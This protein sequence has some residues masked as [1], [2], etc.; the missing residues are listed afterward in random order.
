MGTDEITDEL[1]NV[2]N[3]KWTSE[4]HFYPGENGSVDV[5]WTT[6]FKDSESQFDVQDDEVSEIYVT[7]DL[8]ADEIEII[9]KEFKLK[10]GQLDYLKGDK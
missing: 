2:S 1:N 8:N 4:I 5:M 6:Y 9:N 10:F 3:S 7:C